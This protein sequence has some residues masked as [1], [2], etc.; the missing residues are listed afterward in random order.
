MRGLETLSTALYASTKKGIFCFLGKNVYDT[1]YWSQGLERTYNSA[2]RIGTIY[3]EFNENVLSNERKRKMKNKFIANGVRLI[4]KQCHVPDKPAKRGLIDDRTWNWQI[5]EF[6]GESIVL[7]VRL[8]RPFVSLSLVY[9]FRWIWGGQCFVLV[10]IGLS[11]KSFLLKLF[12]IDG[13]FPQA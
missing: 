7:E 2:F 8:Y 13:F 12:L 10:R 9:N 3:W 1:S 5:L 4:K 6:K 11:H